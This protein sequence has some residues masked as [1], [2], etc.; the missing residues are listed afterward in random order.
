MLII[1]EA[2]FGAHT[3]NQVQPL[4]DIVDETTYTIIMTGTN[5]ERAASI[6]PIDYVTSVTYPELLMQKAMTKDAEKL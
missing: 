6:W 1:D 3:L 5:S 2:D 4:L